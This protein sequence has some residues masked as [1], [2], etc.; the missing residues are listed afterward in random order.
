MLRVLGSLQEASSPPEDD[1]V[2][3]M[4]PKLLLAWYSDQQKFPIS[5]DAALGNLGNDWT[6]LRLKARGAIYKHCT[7]V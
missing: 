6:S 7:W 4:I 1:L 2:S 3:A 5:K